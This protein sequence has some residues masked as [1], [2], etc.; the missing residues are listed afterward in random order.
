M[1]TLSF[2]DMLGGLASPVDFEFTPSAYF[3][4]EGN[5]IE[6][7]FEPDAFY[8]EQ[9]DSRLTAYHSE[10]RDGVITGYLVELGHGNMQDKLPGRP[11]YAG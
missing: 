9:I 6:F 8:A 5:C 2:T 10:E 7:I 11:G 4:P 1:A 3:S